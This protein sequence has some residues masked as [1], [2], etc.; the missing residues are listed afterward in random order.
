[1]RKLVY[2]ASPLSGAVEQNLDFAR[3]ACLNAMSQGVT[4]FA[5]H[6]L[7]PQMLDDGDPAQ[8]ELGMKM[9]NQVLA[10]CDELWLCGDVISTGM[11][12]EYELAEELNIPVRKISMEEILFRPP[13]ELRWDEEPE[14]APGPSMVPPC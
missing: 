10:L 7:Y 13:D 9:G 5:P 12:K 1:M 2:I 8:R 14:Q 11:R 6:L 3:Q 4:P